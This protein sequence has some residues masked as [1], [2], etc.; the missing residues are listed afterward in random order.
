MAAQEIEN[1]QEKMNWHWRNSM[2]PIR[3]LAFDARAAM[4]IPLLLVYLR[5]STIMLTIVTL[6]A[7][8]YVENKGLS[9]PAAMRAIRVSFVG[10]I[11]PGLIS[12]KRRKF[13]DYG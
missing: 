5:L 2:R 13:L 6:M 1:I 4:P 11:R 10:N 12:A 7:F 3:F 8:R 9:Y